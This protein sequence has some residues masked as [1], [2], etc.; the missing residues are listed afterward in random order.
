MTAVEVL[1]K[2]RDYMKER[3]FCK[4]QNKDSEGRVCSIGAVD[5]ASVPSIDYLARINALV[6]LRVAMKNE[7][8]V[9]FNDAK[10]TTKRKVIAAF[11]RAIKAEKAKENV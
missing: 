10:A 11:N 1:I 5:S 6:A 8:I 4:N 7:S 9:D 2:A 3:G